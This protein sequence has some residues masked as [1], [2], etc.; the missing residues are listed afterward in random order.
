M[1]F[2]V[3]VEFYGLKHQDKENILNIM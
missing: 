3:K 1:L 2:N